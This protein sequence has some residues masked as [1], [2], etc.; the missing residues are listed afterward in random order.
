MDFDFNEDQKFIGDTIRKFLEERY[1]IDKHIEQFEGTKR[2]VSLWTDL[3]EL[4]APSMLIDESADGQGMTFVDAALV[5]EE[6][7]RA[8]AP[9]SIVESI[10]A[11]H[12]ISMY[13]SEHQRSRWLPEFAAGTGRIAVAIAE[14]G[15][16]YGLA[17][18]RARASRNGTG[19]KLS[20]SKIMTPDINDVDGL[21]VVTQIDTGMEPVVLIVERAQWE[22]RARC[23]ESMDPAISAGAIDLDGLKIDN[24]D[25]L[26]GLP[27]S[28]GAADDLFE[29]CTAAYALY[30]VGLSAKM[31]ETAVDYASQ[32]VQ[33]GKPIGSFQAIKHKC[34]D[35]AVMLESARSAAYYAAWATATKS[36]DRQKAV[37]MAKA[38]CGDTAAKICND[39]IQVH[40][41]MGFTWD[42]GLHYYLRR[43]KYLEYSFGDARFHRERVVGFVLEELEVGR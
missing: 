3:A 43:A 25:I 1:P 16:D 31:L 33:F 8:L 37:S 40:G 20:A 13:G 11:G 29:A 7:G 41:G 38:Y 34:A 9:M 21:F 27:V 32:R 10:I 23:H 4:D 35:M 5:F 36:D 24:D 18:I 19:W 22:Q 15:A 42:L 6:L 28:S 14:P 2:G 30:Q 12:L 26:G 39:S 17:A